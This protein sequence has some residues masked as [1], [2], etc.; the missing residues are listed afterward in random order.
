MSVLD[1]IILIVVIILLAGFSVVVALTAFGSDILIDWLNMVQST[2]IDGLLLVV[3]LLLLV[4][5]LILLL[6]GEAKTDQCSLT[7]QA[8]LG[9]LRISVNTI[10]DLVA[11]NLSTV[12][13]IKDVTVTVTEVDPLKIDLHVKIAPNLHVPQITESIQ[14]QLSDYLRNT[15]GVQPEAV[16]VIVTGLQT[17]Q[18]RV[19]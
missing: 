3:I 7:R 4:I 10:I 14:M 12:D 6:L 16:N 9:E 15:I 8:A 17:Q 1:K 11:E 2:R 18:R 5:Y 19:Q 13:G